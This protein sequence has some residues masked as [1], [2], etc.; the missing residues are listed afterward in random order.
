MKD[1]LKRLQGK[2]PD[3][4]ARQQGQTIPSE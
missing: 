1:V 3:K 4:A 2:K